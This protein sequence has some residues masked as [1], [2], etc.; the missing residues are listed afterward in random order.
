MGIYPAVWGHHQWTMLHL[1]AFVYPEN[2]DINRQ[3]S[4]IKYLEGMSNNLPCPGCSYHCIN[5]FTEFP[6]Q[7]ESKEKLTK[8]FVDFHNSVNKRTF[9]RE[10]SYSEAEEALKDRCF[11]L[12]N[13]M[14]IKRA[15]DIRIEDHKAIE[16]WKTA[17]HILEEESKTSNTSSPEIVFGVLISIL[18]III[19]LMMYYYFNYINT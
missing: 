18:C 1:M 11:K 4:M 2:P 12:D 6:P 10:L 19:I 8:Y 17:Y 13:W 14:D 5:Y 15:S 16:K 9:K 3:Q 7:V